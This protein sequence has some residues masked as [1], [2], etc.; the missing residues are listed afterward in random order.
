MSP[1]KPVLS[2]AARVAV[3]DYI[4]KARRRN[5]MR[6][7]HR[8]QVVAY[9]IAGHSLRECAEHFAV[10]FQRVHQV[11][12]A[13]APQAMRVRDWRAPHPAVAK[14]TAPEHPSS[15]QGQPQGQPPS[16]PSSDPKI[17]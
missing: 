14:T 12:Q 8:S 9:Y 5:P 13:D 16:P 6:G 11:I 4:A 15:P 3:L 1:T 17:L 2:T 7:E 10:S